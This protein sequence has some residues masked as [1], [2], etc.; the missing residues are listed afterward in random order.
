MWSTTQL[1]DCTVAW[2][3]CSHLR[4]RSP[5]RPVQRGGGW[6]VDD[7]DK[8]RLAALSSSDTQHAGTSNWRHLLP[9][10]MH[11]HPVSE[12]DGR[13]FDPVIG[14]SN[15]CQND[16]G[17][18]RAPRAHNL[19]AACLR[20]RPPAASTAPSCSFFFLAQ[21]GRYNKHYGDLRPR[22]LHSIQA[23]AQ[24]MGQDAQL[25]GHFVRLYIAF[26]AQTDGY[27]GVVET[28][29]YCTRR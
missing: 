11:S 24:T 21:A 7:K 26:L 1:I 12:H 15:R 5:H 23:P 17:D 3:L 4:L 19:Q 25:R 10:Y 29:I 22:R 13:S 14:G 8:A 27:H 6:K 28:C 20:L 16:C 9:Q 2:K 18:C